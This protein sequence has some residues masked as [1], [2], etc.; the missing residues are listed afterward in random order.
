MQIKPINLIQFNNI[1][2]T[3]TVGSS[4]PNPVAFGDM[5]QNAL[6]NVNQLQQ[7]AEN[8]ARQL[9]LGQINDVHSVMIQ[10]ERA[11][12][13]LELTVQVSSRAINAYNEIM[14]MQM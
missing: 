6:N 14:R 7:E 12:L 13:A 5:L 9:A 8:A 11:A 4:T 3:N 2:T 1:T 10:T